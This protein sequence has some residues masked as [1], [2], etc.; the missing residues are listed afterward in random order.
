MAVVLYA[1]A[2]A[3]EQVT[4]ISLTF[5]I[6]ITGIVCTIYTSLG[7]MKA[8]VATDLFQVI[9]MYSGLIAIIFVGARHVGGFGEIWK[10]AEQSGRIEFF[11]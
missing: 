10:R 11:E 2:L 1:P 9:V 3:I 6:V 8:V 5:S 7:G 4:G